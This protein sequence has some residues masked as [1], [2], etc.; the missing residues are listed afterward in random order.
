MAKRMMVVIVIASVFSL[1][2]AAGF[3]LGSPSAVKAASCPDGVKITQCWVNPPDS[4]GKSSC[5]IAVEVPGMVTEIGARPAAVG[6]SKVF[7]ITAWYTA[8]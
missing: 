6:T 3:M 7:Y 1:G 8:E 4:E 2:L 5:N